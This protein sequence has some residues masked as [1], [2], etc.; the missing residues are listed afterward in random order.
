MFDPAH[1][2]AEI[3]QEF[4]DAGE[5]GLTAQEIENMAAILALENERAKDRERKQRKRIQGRAPR[6]MKLCAQC[7]KILPK[8]SGPG[9]PQVYCS[10]ACRMKHNRTCADIRPA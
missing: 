1:L 9:K 7:G 5:F 3:L 6:G 4:V 2:Q 8:P 10:N